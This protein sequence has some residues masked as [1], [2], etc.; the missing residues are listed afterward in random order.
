MWLRWEHR[1]TPKSAAR[2]PGKSRYRKGWTSLLDLS[3]KKTSRA[4]AKIQNVLLFNLRFNENVTLAAA[5]DLW[6]EVVLG[7]TF[8]IREKVS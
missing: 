7:L 8:F 6:A 5:E 1:G 2:L 3:A 4:L